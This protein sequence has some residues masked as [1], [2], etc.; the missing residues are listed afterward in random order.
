[1]TGHAS[2]EDGQSFFRA[3]TET[4]EC[5]NA[6]APEIAAV[7]RFRRP[8][9]VFLSGCR[10]GESPN[11]GAIFSLAE[12]LIKQG[13]CRSVLGWGRAVID[14]TATKTAAHLYSK[15][16]AGYQLAEALASTYQHLITAKVEDW[17]LLRLYVEGQCPKALVKPLGD[18]VWLPE[19]PIHGQ[20]LDSQ[21]IVR[22]ATAQEFVGRRRIIQRSLRALRVA[23][24]L[25]II[26]HGLGG[27]GKS[28]VAARL[29]ER[30]HG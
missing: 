25:G 4:G 6:Y 15:L 27:V 23:D 8:Q 19:E 30:L 10:T 5:H 3:E 22:V 14:V 18:Q 17:H 21:G 20:F 24:K 7:L 11:D 1:M 9:L 26:I 12:S 2:I 28:S 29:L 16:A 13:G